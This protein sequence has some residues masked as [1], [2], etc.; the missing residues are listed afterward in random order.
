VP[1]RNRIGEEGQGFRY[2]LDGLNPERILLA[3]EALGL[4]RASIE[5]ASRYAR[6]RIVFDRPIGQNQGIAFP[7]AEARMRLD[8]ARLMAR[9]AAWRYDRGEPCGAEANMAKFLCADAGFQATD[10]ALQTLG[11]MGYA[12]E[13]HIERYFREAR[14]L[15]LAPVSQEMVLNYVAQHVLGLPK[16][17]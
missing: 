14:L 8:A 6:D 1:A 10:V 15:R 12:K 13:F 7:L 5:Q 3:H 17:Y 9:L 11:G 2:L 4:G 16:S